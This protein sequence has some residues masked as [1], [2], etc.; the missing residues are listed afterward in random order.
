MADYDRRNNAAAR[1]AYAK[2]DA[3]AWRTAD[4]GPLLLADDFAVVFRKLSPASERKPHVDFSMTPERVYAAGPSAFPQLA[5]VAGPMT[6]VEASER[7][8]LGVRLMAQTTAGGTWFNAQSL[9][10]EPA[11]LP[12]PVVPGPAA[13][14]SDAQLKRFAGVRPALTAYLEKKK[15]SDRIDTASVE[16]L[17][18]ELRKPGDSSLA[19]LTVTCVPFPD[20]TPGAAAVWRADA[21]A[22]GVLA[23]RCQT[24]A[25]LKDRT[26]Y[27][28]LPER[29]R[30][31]LGIRDKY[32]QDF[33]F[34]FL[35][36]TLVTL[37]ESGPAKVIGHSTQQIL[38]R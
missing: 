10:V 5:L 22:I 18:K 21:G 6:G 34:S 26:T 28:K 9:S 1:T 8:W 12:A 25:Q 37:P 31:V 17:R 30:A 33:T 32:P 19:N 11:D 13:Q 36:Q 35:L 16:P 24:Y 14:V 29:T 2:M 38:T 15:A 7:A 4:I 27:M 23:L 3:K 20:N